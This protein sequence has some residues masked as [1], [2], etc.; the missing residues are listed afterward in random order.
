MS[1][2][3]IRD[4]RAAVFRIPAERPE[5]DGTCAWSSTTMVLA[6]VEGEGVT[7]IGYS[8][9]DA[10]AALLIRDRFAPLLR[11]ASAMNIEA[12]WR[13]M[14]ADLRNT[15]RPGIGAHAVSAVDTAL[16]DLKAK[17]LG[18]SVAALLG[19]VR[20][21]VPVYASGGFTSYDE[22]T[23]M[24]Q[25]AGWAEEGFTMVKMK[26]GRDPGRDPARVAA[27]RRAVGDAC[28]LMVDAN[29]AL[30]RHDALA[31]AEA[32]AESNVAYFEEP[33][34]SDDRDGLQWVRGHVPRG[35]AVAA[36]EYGYDPWYFAAMLDASCVDVLQA[37]ATRCLGI[38]GL[39]KVAALCEAHH[40]PL[41]T[42]CAPSIHLHAAAA[43][44]P[45]VHLEWFHDHVRIESMLFDG[46][47]GA[48]VGMVRPMRDRTGH[49]ISLR[50][51][52]A[53][54]WRVA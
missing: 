23:L 51:S 38:T 29:G 49:G 47:A 8:Y 27:A 3:R 28:T 45:L 39:M 30:T 48:R 10:A 41:S 25:L 35:M 40:V 13:A 19:Q 11:G 17:V 26:V 5:S 50:E 4:V 18:V 24:R 14:V 34:S 52:D 43:A 53:R 1:D 37:D 46:F 22:E 36:G 31:Q 16:W 32:F 15:G 12:A 2:P 54:Q 42:H 9:A 21:A 20:D 33:V 7:G 6:E 44:G